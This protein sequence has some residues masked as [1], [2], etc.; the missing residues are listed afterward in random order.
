MRDFF[1]SIPRETTN[2]IIAVI[3]IGLIGVFTV[4]LGQLLNMN[5]QIQLNELKTR[6]TNQVLIGENYKK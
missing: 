1:D 4:K 5:A 3:L 2:F 6:I